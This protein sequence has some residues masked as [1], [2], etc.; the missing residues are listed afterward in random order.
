MTDL[1]V[2]Q[3]TTGT[4]H[5][6]Q[7]IAAALVDQRLAACVQVSGPIESTYH[8]D[9]QQQTSEEWLVVIKTL[10]ARFADVERAILAMHPYEQPEIL[11]LPVAEVNAN[12]A[13]W[14]RERCGI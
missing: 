1:I 7:E 5:D 10:A 9:G 11:A 2:I 14:L 6:A 4:R 3:T 12:Y 13:K 8:W